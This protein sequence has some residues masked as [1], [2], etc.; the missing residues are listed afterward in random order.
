MSD[1]RKLEVWQKAHELMLEVHEITRGI[2]GSQY[3][4]LKN[5][6]L[7]AAMSI[8]ANIVE[9]RAQRSDREFGRFLGYAV[10][11]SSE[12]EYHIFAAKEIGVLTSEKA[13][14]LIERTIRVRRMLIGLRKKLV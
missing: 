11:S 8:P 13:D 14:P 3:L 12:L 10:A 5:Q 4:S 1:F 7:R 9:G 2:R 6:I